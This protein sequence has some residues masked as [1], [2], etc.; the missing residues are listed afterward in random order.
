MSES[1]QDAIAQAGRALQRYQRSVQHFDDTVGRRLG[2]NMADMRC[3]D[4]ISEGPHTAGEIALATGLR[5]A[6]TTAL[7]DRLSARG[8]TRRVPSPD[9][10]RRVLVELTEE[11]QAQVWEAYGPLVEEGGVVFDGLNADEILA[12]VAVV[13]RMTELTDRHRSR[14]EN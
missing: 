13:E 2:L 6:A 1:R 12:L 10:R 7:I 3:L 14:I 9:D 5:P 4:Y 8:L 11:G